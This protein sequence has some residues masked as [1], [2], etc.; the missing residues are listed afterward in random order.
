MKK[1]ILVLAAALGAGLNLLS[2][3]YGSS[4]YGKGPPSHLTKRVLVSQGVSSTS[5]FGALMFVNGSNDTIAR[6]SPLSAGTA[7]G[8]MAISP[9]RNILIAFDSVSNSVFA[10]DTQTETTLGS[11]RLPGA[12][13]SMVVPSAASIGYAAVPT[14]TVTGYSFVGGIEEMNL[15]AG[16]ITTTIGLTNA[17]TVISDA[18]GGEL[19]V[20]NGT[21]SVTVLNPGAAVPPVDTSCLT[22]QPNVVCTIIPGFDKPVYGVINGTT[23]YI[24]NCG[25]QCNGVQASVS[26]LDLSTLTITGN[27]PLDAATWAII[28][29]STLYVAGTPTIN[30][31]CTGQTTAATTCGTLDIVDLT[32]FTKTGSI[33]ITDGYHDRMDMS[34][35]GQLFIGSY[36]CTN[37]GNVNNPNGE[38]RGCLTIYNTNT[39]GVVIPPDNGN[40]GGLQSF[41]TRNIE[42]VAEGGALRVYDTN[43]DVLLIND[44]VPEGTIELVGY[45]GDIKAIDFF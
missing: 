19:L 12:T 7:P 1:R 21:D 34:V 4:S 39:G 20:F 45:I 30:N 8:L 10:V 22:G 2:C 16:G 29:G 23:A 9:T 6:V 36:D 40:V 24:L 3:G 11:L 15:S 27:L 35:N 37:I 31:A 32:T 38:V 28:S 17:Q 18:D 5:L 26:I 14:A 41:T 13:S 33:V 43:R 42:Y 44:F 25:P